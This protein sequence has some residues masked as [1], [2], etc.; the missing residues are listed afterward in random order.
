MNAVRTRRAVGGVLSALA[1]AA[2]ALAAEQ[3]PPSSRPAPTSGESGVGTTT[4]QDWW[5]PYSPPCVERENVFEF[6]EKPAVKNL[7]SDRYEISF[8]VK[9]KATYEQQLAAVRGPASAPVQ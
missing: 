4:R 7:G 9:G 3:D 6:T 8:A 5:K 2:T 1:V